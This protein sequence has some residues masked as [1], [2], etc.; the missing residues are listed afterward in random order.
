MEKKWFIQPRWVLGL[1]LLG[2]GITV[3]TTFYGLSQFSTKGE[4]PEVSPTATIKPQERKITALGRLEPLGEVISLGV[5]MN[6]NVDRV[7]QLLVKE[8]DKVEKGQIIAIL[9]SRDRLQSLL[10]QQ[11]EQIRV[12]EARLAQVNAGAK[13]GEIVAQKATIS[14]VEAQLQGDQITQQA[15]IDRVEAQW[16]GEKKAQQAT[17]ERV[18]AQWEGEKKAQQATLDKLSAELKNAETEYQR[19]EQLYQEGAIAQSLLDT[20]RLTVETTRQQIAEGKANFNRINSTFSKQIEEANANLNRINST[21]PQQLEEANATLERIKK[22]GVEQLGEASATLNKIAEIRPVDVQVAQAEVESAIAQ[23]KRAQTELDQAYVR[24]PMTGQVL[25]IHTRSGE[26]ISD[27]G[28]IELGKTDQMV[29][30]AEVYQTDIKQVK[31]GD[32]AKISSQ[33]F[34]G[35]LEGIVKEIGLQVKRQNVF[36]NQP[37]ENL[38][39][40]VVEVQ[41]Y[42]NPQDSQKV[43]SLTN[44]QVDVAIDSPPSK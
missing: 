16:E 39:S 25:K 29:V 40:R 21:F 30:V 10:D 12:A 2:T 41:I 4:S 26:K 31:I 7:S 3:T 42:L 35:D 18:Y 20:K 13:T 5:S 24:A 28:I 14:R 37:G 11:K 6:L 36:S 15:V 23:L 27:K 34:S 8:G 38:D 33:A 32:S 19:H 43:A 9:D 1:I 22:T 44:L 17:I